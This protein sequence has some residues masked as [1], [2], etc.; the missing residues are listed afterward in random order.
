MGKTD[1]IKD[2]RV[3]VYV[4]TI[5]RKKRWTEHA[6]EADESLSQFVQQCVEYAIEQ[7]GPDFTELGEESKEIQELEEQVSDL[8]QDIKQKEIVIEKLESEL[9]AL[10]SKPFR[11][12]DYEGQREYDQELI[13]ELQ[14]ADRI[15]GDELLRRL[16]VDP[17]DTEVVKG[18]DQQLQQLEDY[19]LVRST[20]QGWVWDA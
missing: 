6:D 13:E 3:D 17:S 12:E 11:D 18:V 19:G 20:P 15:T 4:D 8:Q 9:K 14:R 5:D 7:G 16:D 2:R 10:R 1:T